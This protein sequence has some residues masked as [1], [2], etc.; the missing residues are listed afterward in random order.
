MSLFLPT[1]KERELPPSGM[2][3]AVCYGVVELGTQPTNYGSKPQIQ[4]Q[5][6]LIEKTAANGKPLTLFRR[7]TMSADP[8]STLRQDLESWVGRT[9]TDE[10]LGRLDLAQF[11]GATVLLNI[12][13]EARGDKTYA[14]ITAVLPPPEGRE[15]R[16]RPLSPIVEFSLQQRPF[17]EDGYERLPDWLKMVL[18]TL[19]STRRRRPR[20]R[21][22]RRCR[23]GCVCSWRCN[24]RSSSQRQRQPRPAISRA[25]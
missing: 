17:D 6:E 13:H 15:R 3:F 12:R 8:R 1:R 16:A 14:N 10:E 9:L 7:Y 25:A 19:P 4:L 11:L 18:R 2:Q 22:R 21:R 5:F 24:P 23:T 20:H